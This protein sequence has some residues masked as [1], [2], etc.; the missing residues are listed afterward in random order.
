[1]THLDYFSV[2]AITALLLG[3]CGG[4]TSGDRQTDSINSSSGGSPSGASSSGGGSS[5]DNPDQSGG[6][7]DLVAPPNAPP[8]D[9]PP[10]DEVNHIEPTSRPICPQDEPTEGDA[11]G[12]T[13]GLLCSYGD[14]PDW[15]CRQLVKCEGTWKHQDRNCN[16]PPVDY[17]PSKMPHG[18]ECEVQDY[19]GGTVFLGSG[20]ECNYEDKFICYCNACSRTNICDENQSRWECVGPPQEEECP[21]VAPNLGEGCSSKGRQCTYGDPCDASGQ[22]SFCRNGIWELGSA[23]CVD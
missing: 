11:C 9:T 20:V 22:V 21:T 13:P 17:C 18:E 6:T 19:A 14:S 3:G 1:M 23:Q 8:L 5:E 2:T 12:D 7:D 16:E 10:V 15:S 4:T